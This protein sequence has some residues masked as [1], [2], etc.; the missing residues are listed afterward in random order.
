MRHDETRD[1]LIYTLRAEIYGKHHPERQL[2]R[3]PNTWWDAFKEA[4]AP[5][6]FLRRYP[7]RYITVNVSL[8]E[9]YPEFKPAIPGKPPVVRVLINKTISPKSP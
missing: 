2:V 5:D 6:W 9:T 3:Y 7:V 8:E 4:W 1:R